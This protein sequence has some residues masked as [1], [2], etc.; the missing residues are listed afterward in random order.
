MGI[1]CMLRFR[2]T[3]GNVLSCNLIRT[4]PFILTMS[5]IAYASLVCGFNLQMKVC[6]IACLVLNVL[7]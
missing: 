2:N 7:E 4:G 3:I 6:T 1:S 5:K